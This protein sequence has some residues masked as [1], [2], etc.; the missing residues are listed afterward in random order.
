MQE[1]RW[2]ITTACCTDLAVAS[3]GRV[4]SESCRKEAILAHPGNKLQVS[5]RP[6]GQGLFPR[7]CY[8]PQLSHPAQ[9]AIL[10]FV[11]EILQVI[12]FKSSEMEGK[13]SRRTGEW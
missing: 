7:G 5:E 1:P 2:E 4:H 6:R 11:L 10:R 8:W 9:S 13:R 12:K 3:E